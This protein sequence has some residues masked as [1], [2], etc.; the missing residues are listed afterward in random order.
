MRRFLP[1]AL[2]G[3]L[4]VGVAAGAA[5]GQAQSPG[6]TPA[7]WVD[8]VLDATV[9]A[10]TAHLQFS[11]VTTSPNPS[12][13][14]ADAGT[15]VV[16]FANG[17]FRVTELYRQAQLESTNG[18]ATRLGEEIFGQ[19]TIA[20]GQT[21]YRHLT[22]P[23]SFTGW[24][25]SHFPR[26]E[27]Q[28]FGLDAATGA[29][30]AVSGLANLTPVAAVRSLGSGVVNGASATKYQI[31]DEPLYV[32]GAHGRTLLVH[33]FAPTIVWVDRQGRLLRSRAVQSNQGETVQGEP[34]APGGSHTFT[35]GP[36]TT[37]AT[38][39][40]S[41]LGAPVRIT[42][43][44]VNAPSGGTAIISLKAKGSTSPCRG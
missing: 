36:S 30:D 11:S 15:G 9:A 23:P 26:Q 34:N 13:R 24:M 28:A 10:G 20:I 14:A 38:L 39:T 27:H 12:Q 6:V 29:E 8:D 16:D 22:S 7:Q 1:W 32:C 19:E 5:V 31:T 18:G 25:R 4:G 2:L 41:D 3:L 40:F 37:V 44:R 43:P 42:A 17:N 35:I 21:V 33:R